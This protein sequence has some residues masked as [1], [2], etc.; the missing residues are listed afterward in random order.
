MTRINGAGTI[1]RRGKA[2]W[3]I[4]FNLGR[5]PVTGRYRYSNWR[6]VHGSKATAQQALAEYR[7]ELEC[8]LRPDAD[9]MTFREYAELFHES[10]KAT[11]GLAPGTVRQERQVLG[12][13]YR[14]LGDI[15]LRDI[16][17]MTIDAMLTRHHKD[18]GSADQSRRMYAKLRQ[19]LADACLKDC[20]MRN[21]ADKVKPPK[22]SRPDMRFLDQKEVA[23]LLGALESSMSNCHNKYRPDDERRAFTHCHVTAVRLALATGMRRGE[24]LGLT[25]GCVDFEEGTVR[26]MQQMTLDGIRE[27]KTSQSK[28]VISIDDDTWKHLQRW[29]AAQADYLGGLGIGQDD[30][31]PVIANEVGGF[32]DPS[33]FSRWWRSFRGRYG[34]EGLRFHTLR[35]SQATLLLVSGGC[36][37]KTVMG[38]LGHSLASTTLDLYASVMPGKDRDAA[39]FIGSIL[40]GE[41]QSESQAANR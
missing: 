30:G 13:I 40:S 16:D 17:A 29:K 9:R 5:D 24:V 22:A 33:G 32:H 7:Q 34:F 21:P 39:R 10:R 3:R 2:T 6:T 11:G 1:Q 8:G 41:T 20:L 38:R 37:L 36:D 23:R 15:T 18:G 19:V 12:H 35:H 14:Y 31:T 26:V 28:R 27:T 4:R 25:W